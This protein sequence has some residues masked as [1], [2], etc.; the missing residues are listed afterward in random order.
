M[1]LWMEDVFERKL[2]VLGSVYKEKKIKS[3]LGL[4]L[5]ALR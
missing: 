4:D 3:F 2:G 1:V 5:P